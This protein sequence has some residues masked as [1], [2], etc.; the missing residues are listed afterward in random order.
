MNSW[1]ILFIFL[2]LGAIVFWEFI[3]WARK[4]CGQERL[5][6]ELFKRKEVK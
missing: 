3:N 6:F 2:F 5:K 4:E 1:I